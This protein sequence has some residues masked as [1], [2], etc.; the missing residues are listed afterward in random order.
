MSFPP[1]RKEKGT[2]KGGGSDGTVS[3][4]LSLFCG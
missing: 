2:E 4:L 1:F 3:E